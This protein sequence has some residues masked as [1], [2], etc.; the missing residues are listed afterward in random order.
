MEVLR[1]SS[2]TFG[3]KSVL[4][5]EWQK[6]NMPNVT[7]D[8]YGDKLIKDQVTLEHLIPKS[9]GGKSALSNY[10]LANAENNFRRS[11]FDLDSFTQPH[12]IKAYLKQFEGLKIPKFNGNE[13]I[14]LITK[15][16]KKMGIKL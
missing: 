12:T 13:Y 1:V 9:K 11:N 15:T 16:L 5:S 8:I 3:Y 7:I 10:A 2:I 6:G 4:K 14:K